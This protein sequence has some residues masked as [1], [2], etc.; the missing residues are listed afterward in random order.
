MAVRRISNE[1]SNTISGILEDP[2]GGVIANVKTTSS[3]ITIWD[4]YIRGPSDTP[5]HTPDNKVYHLRIT[6][7]TSYPFKPPVIQFMTRVFHPNISDTGVIC[8]DMLKDNWSPALSI[9][10]LLQS[11]SSL[12]AAPNSSD[13]LNPDAGNLYT[14]NIDEYNRTVREYVRV[15]TKTCPPQDF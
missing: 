4:V 1:L 13:P 8:L 5:Y 10:K 12:L 11:I 7:P 9:E 6:F 14:R 3:N 15:H 2:T